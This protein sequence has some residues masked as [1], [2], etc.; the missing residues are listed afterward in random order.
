MGSSQL[1]EG[2][3]DLMFDV[4][5]EGRR[6]PTGDAAPWALLHGLCRLIPCVDVGY[7]RHDYR[8]RETL[9]IQYAEQ[10]GV[11]GL[12]AAEELPDDEKEQFWGL[13]WSGMCSW[14]QRTGNLRQVLNSTDFFPTERERLADPSSDY[15]PDWKYALEVELPAPPGE[16]RRFVFARGAGPAFS[17]RDRQVLELLR[18]HLV[19]LCAEAEK[20]RCRSP[21]AESPGVGGAR[22][23]GRGAV[24]Q[25][26][27]RRALLS[28]WA[29]C[30]STWSTSAAGS[31]CIPSP[32]RRTP[33]PCVR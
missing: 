33:S 31:G 23:G 12:V 17:E 8:R 30:A 7:Q 11:Q 26:D 22:I 5:A 13:W 6:D 18:P 14:P 29:P 16:A 20:R 25:R 27:R 2:D 3:A 15:C 10:G 9:V 32:L 28:P 1:R 21:T 19:E 24:L 4:I